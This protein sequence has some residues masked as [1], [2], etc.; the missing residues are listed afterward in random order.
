M[1]EPAEHRSGDE[2][3]ILSTAYLEEEV[4]RMA[5]ER[6][7]EHLCIRKCG[8]AQYE[9]AF[10]K[11]EGGR[12]VSTGALRLVVTAGWFETLDLLS[13]APDRIKAFIRS[14]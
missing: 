11:K 13:D 9:V 2:W 4:S 12:L 5:Y 6:W 1:A 7:Q 8:G 14:T 3:H 10:C